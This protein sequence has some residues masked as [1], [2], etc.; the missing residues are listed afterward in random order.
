VEITAGRRRAGETAKVEVH[1][2]GTAT[3]YTGSSAHGQGHHTA[4]AM[5]VTA[6]S[7]SRWTRSRSSTATPT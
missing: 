2:D 4:Y 5:L 6:S 7:A 1:D 3:V